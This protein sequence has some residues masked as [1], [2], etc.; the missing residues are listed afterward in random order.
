MN[1]II[2][3]EL[4]APPS[5]VYAFKSLALIATHSYHYELYVEVDWSERDCYHLWLKNNYCYDYVAD[6]I[7]INELKG[8]RVSAANNYRL[9]CDKINDLINYIRL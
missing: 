2:A 7:R 5:E 6:L 3:A 9:T 8:K 1:L 4:T